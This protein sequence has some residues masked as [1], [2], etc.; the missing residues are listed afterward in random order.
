VT[1][2]A[3]GVLL[4]LDIADPVPA[5]DT[6][7]IPHQSQQAFWGVAQAGEK[8]VCGPEGLAIS[9]ALGAH[10]DDQAVAIQA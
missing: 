9:C 3:I 7:P 6:S 8:Q 10:L 1:L 5:F 2:V 4:E